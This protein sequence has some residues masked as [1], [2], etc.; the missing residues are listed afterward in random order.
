MKTNARIA[1]IGLGSI[2]SRHVNTLLGMGYAD[3]VGVDLRPMPQEER[4]PV[5]GELSEIEWWMP[6]HALIC[7]P[8]GLHYV[9]AKR[10]VDRGIPTFIEKPMTMTTT[11]ARNLCAAAHMNKSVLA[12]GYMER[13]HP[14][15]Q[16]FYDLRKRIKSLQIECLWK[17]L[18]KTYPLDVTAE[19]SHAL[20]LALWMLGPVSTVWRSKTADTATVRIKHVGGAFS[21]IA[22]SLIADMPY[23]K[24]SAELAEGN[25]LSERYGTMKAEWDD[26]YRAELQAFLDGAPLCA[27]HE[28]AAVVELIERM[29]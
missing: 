21:M 24:L 5:V 25:R 28:G 19:S 15:V 18:K 13:A 10:F 12:V 23:R 22:M 7:S 9:H 16:R 2:G 27:G 6:T 20:D 4:L 11:E 14:V 29:K 1:V 17:G 8:P 26:C 3:L